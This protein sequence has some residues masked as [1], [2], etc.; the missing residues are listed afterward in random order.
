ML[1]ALP[2]RSGGVRQEA[3]LQG[4]T[5][6]SSTPT[7]RLRPPRTAHYRR[8][9]THRPLVRSSPHQPPPR[10]PSSR[11]PQIRCAFFTYIFAMIGL[12]IAAHQPTYQKDT[13][14]CSDNAKDC[15]LDPTVRV[16]VHTCGWCWIYRRP[17]GVQVAV[18]P[19]NAAAV[20]DPPAPTLTYA[21]SLAQPR[22]TLARPPPRC[23]SWCAW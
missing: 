14:D 18:W 16:W 3:R 15:P 2:Q 20:L 7:T 8:N 4:G 9:L 13:D 6:H 11:P 1:V 10:L 12:L 21:R 19:A 23:R 22:R 17:G 5:Y